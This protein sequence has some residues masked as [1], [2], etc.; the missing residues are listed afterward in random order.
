MGVL[1]ISIYNFFNAR[2]WL[3]WLFTLG[4]FVLCGWLASR[5]RLEEDITRILPRD[6]KIDH[7]QQFMQNSKFADKLVVM[8][9]QQDTTAPAEPDSL[10]ALAQAFTEGLQQARLQPYIKTVQGQADDALVME[11]MQAVQNHLPVFLDEKDY[12][13]ID[14]LITPQA[15]RQ[16]M[17]DNY[18]TLL[19]PAGL[20]LKRMIQADPV[21]ISWLGVKKLEQLQAGGQFELYNGYVISKD[22]RNILLF[23]TPQYPPNETGKNKQF[24][25]GLDALMDSLHTQHPRRQLSYFG[26]TAV[27][28][29]NAE[30]LRQDTYFTQGITVL[31]LIVLIALFFRK[32]RAPLLV[33]L[34]VVF[35]ALFSLAMMYLLKGQVSVIAL[36]AGCVVLGIAVNYSLHVFNHYRHLPNI[37]QVIKDLA[38]PMTVGGLTTVGGFLCLQFVKSPMLQDIGL[39]AAFSLVG[40]SLF[41]LIILPHLMAAGKPAPVQARHN[42]IDRIS[43]WRPERSKYLVYG[44]LALTV[45]FFFTARHVTFESDMM[46]MNFMPERLQKAEAQL[47][48]LNAFAAQSVYMISEGGTL[49][50]A[51]Q[52]R[53]A[54]ASAIH[55]LEQ[56]GIVKQVSGTGGLVLSEQAQAEKIA[57][58]KAYWT[59][60]KQARVLQ[61]LRAEGA[62]YRFRPDAFDNFATLLSKEYA[63]IPPERSELLQ[64]SGVSDYVTLKPG[65]ASVISLLKVD[66]AQKAAVYDALEQQPGTVVFDKQYTA[67]RLAE[68]IRDEFNTIAWMT[69]LLVF[70]ALLLSYG[71]IELAL[72]TFIPMLI[73]W[74]WI[75]G[76]MGLFG[77]P[78]NIVNI[79][80]STFIFGLGDDYSIFTMDGLQQEYKN[81]SK[82]LPSFRSSIIFSAITTIL[83]LGVLIFAR[84]PSLRSIALI[85]VIGIMSVVLTSQ[86]LIPLFFNWLITRR[87][88]NGR[89]PWKLWSWGKSMFAFTYYATGAVLLTILGVLLTRINPFNI[90]KGKKIYHRILSSFTW[91]LLHIMG[92][93][94]KRTINTT[95]EDFKKPAVVISNH[96]SFLDILMSTAMHPNVVL[97][98]NQWVYNSPLFGYVVKMADY[99]PVAEGVEGSIDKLRNRVENGYSIV[100]Y[101]EGTRST[102]ASIKRFHKGAFYLAEQL[103]LDILPAVIHGTAYTMSKNDFLLKDGIVTM[104]YLP[105]IKPEDKR[106]GDNYST[107][108]RLI[109][110]YFRQEYEQLRNEI[111]TPA[112]YREQLI[113]QYLYKGPVLEWYMR[114]KTKLENNY[115]LFH[116]L[117]PKSGRIMD[118]GCGYGFMSY[119]LHF[120]CP[121]R[122]ILG[123]DYDEEKI[124]VAQHCYLRGEQLR[125]EAADITQYP[126]EHQDA[127]VMLDVLHYLQ[128]DAQEKLLQQCISRLNPGGVIIVRDGDADLAERHK[129]TRLTELFS[130]RLLGFNKTGNRPLSFFSATALRNIV[131]RNGAIMERI[132]NTRY[133]S[134]VIFIIKH[135]FTEQYA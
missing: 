97:L 48:R 18:N 6:K 88:K 78:F 64:V 43:R 65:A 91:S 31:L 93:I 105:R 106:W 52:R 12:A 95:G 29:G 96:Q 7:L 133:T 24:L 126:L 38:M 60:E 72:I 55:A 2:K 109:S 45:L 4:C 61:M 123:V 100:I 114:I 63:P 14:S 51:L 83:G 101:P 54:A 69:S 85:A 129:G 131:E 79:I 130:T 19:S 56:K 22:H 117:L 121:E 1:F 116:E 132:D 62:Q 81:G 50:E 113:Y 66:P 71:R 28:V 21:G 8:L 33:M 110:R 108:T 5:I 127:F 103:Q 119:M 36:G 115:A 26:A 58:W 53:E 10:A 30:Q 9:A 11:L 46:R 3:L 35:G 80:L 59:P 16:K 67:N 98:T 77:I 41:S 42:V 90:E 68:I 99:Y 20:V 76:I 125:F 70:F 23:I 87:V 118:I 73:S 89:P 107:R 82:H 124:A 37:R 122:Q 49:G 134:N 112:Y 39:F 86:V 44:I 47:N 40:A 135:S 102:D 104:K 27:S 84:H 32:K 13:A 120:L 92:N 17:A 111:E 34:P 25:A 15:L 94:R 74:V 57:R 75:L 128:P